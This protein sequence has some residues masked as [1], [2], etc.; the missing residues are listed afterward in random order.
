MKGIYSI[1]SYSFNCLYEASADRKSLPLNDTVYKESLQKLLPS[2][3]LTN[4]LK[5][6]IVYGRQISEFFLC[7]LQSIKSTK[8][9]QNSN[10][11]AQHIQ[12]HL[13]GC[14]CSSTD[15]FPIPLQQRYS[16]FHQPAYC[17]P[18][19]QG[20]LSI[21]KHKMFCLIGLTHSLLQPGIWRQQC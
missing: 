1:K 13:A 12:H 20:I 16:T 2:H 15:T 10:I 5:T 7:Y 21:I 4:F 14:N 19:P 8:K 9:H 18:T 6:Y 17:T 3:L 11:K